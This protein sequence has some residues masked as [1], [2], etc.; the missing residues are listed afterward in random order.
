MNNHTPRKL[1]LIYGKIHP[2][3]GLDFMSIVIYYIGMRKR[4]LTNFFIP[5]EGQP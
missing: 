4:K 5:E 2:G 1:L 3:F